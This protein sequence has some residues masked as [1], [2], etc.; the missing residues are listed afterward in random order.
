MGNLIALSGSK[1]SGKTTALNY[2]HGHVMLSHGIIK[3]FFIDEHGRLVVNAEYHGENNK[4]F[5]RMG[6]F[7]LTQED[8]AFITYAASTFWPLIKGYNFADPLK[9]ICMGMFGLTKE[10]C[11]GT[12][13]QKNSLTSMS[14]EDMPGITDGFAA[15]PMTAR[16]FMQFFGTNVCRKMND[17]AHINPTIDQIK[18]EGA[19]VAAIGDC[20]FKNEIE[21]VHKEGGK[22][23]YFTRNEGSSDGHESEQASKNKDVCD[24][25]ID[26]ANM[27]IEEQNESVIKHLYDWGILPRNL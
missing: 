6:V 26:N 13:D 11:H 12:D 2:L 24:A 27:G 1:Q 7:D 25:I 19:E 16:E 18:A 23:L 14:W 22:V 9:R 20:R 8:E 10:Q 4:K 5:E 15:G 21:A 3:K 17:G